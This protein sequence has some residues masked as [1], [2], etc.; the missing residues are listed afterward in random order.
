[1][2]VWVYLE[3]VHDI[4]VGCELQRGSLQS[5]NCLS[6]QGYYVVIRMIRGFGFLGSKAYRLGLWGY[7]GY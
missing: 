1:M 4:S 7:Y 6:L 3:A 5:L 2:S